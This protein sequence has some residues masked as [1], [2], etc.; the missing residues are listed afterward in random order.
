[1]SRS[2]RANGVNDIN[3]LQIHAGAAIPAALMA[4]SQYG[5]SPKYSL[6]ERI[7]SWAFAW[8]ERPGIC[9]AWI[10]DSIS[11]RATGRDALCAG[12]G[13]KIGTSC[14]ATIASLTSQLR[15][16]ERRV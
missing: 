14:P 16:E 9:T 2:V 15:S 11:P 4:R 6:K 8:F 12:A 7:S 1:M 13:G 3:D 5:G 10:A